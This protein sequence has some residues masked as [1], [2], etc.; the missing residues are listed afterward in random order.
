[1]ALT[2]ITKIGGAALEDPLMLEGDL[3]VSG[4]TTFTR[5]VQAQAGVFGESVIGIQSATTQVGTGVTQLNF[6][7]VG[8]TFKFHEATNTV[9][10]SIAGGGGGG[11]VAAVDS[12]DKVAFIHFGGF[13]A[14]GQVKSPQKFSDIF[15]HVDATVDIE[16]GVTVDID[17]DCLLRIIDKDDYDINYFAPTDAHDHLY[18]QTNVLRDSG[19]DDTIRTTFETN[20][21][22][23]ARKKVGY[24]KL[25]KDLEDEIMIDI[26]SGVTI[27]IGD[28]C[29]L[30]I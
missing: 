11:G 28:Q 21:E 1:M 7:G 12:L 2:G 27:D 30:I 18:P 9:D 5:T 8:N 3:H 23:N 19:F 26:E 4:I 15:T 13:T 17:E 24:V 29:V 14:S 25:P 22:L 6:I 16:D 10:V 20:G